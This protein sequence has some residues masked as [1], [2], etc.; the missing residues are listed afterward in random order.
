MCLLGRGVQGSWSAPVWTLMP[1]CGRRRCSKMQ[2]AVVSLSLSSV[3]Y[4][5]L[6]PCTYV[7][8]LSFLPLIDSWRSCRCYSLGGRSRAARRGE[9][10]LPGR[11][12]CCRGTGTGSAGSTGSGRSSMVVPPL[13][14]AVIM[15]PPGSGKGTVSARII[16]HFG[17]KH[18]SSGDLL[19]DNMQKRTGGIGRG[20]GGVRGGGGAS[21]FVRPTGAVPTQPWELP[22]DTAPLRER[23]TLTAHIPAPAPGKGHAHSSH[24]CPRPAPSVPRCAAPQSQLCVPPP[25]QRLADFTQLFWRP[26]AAEVASHPQPGVLLTLSLTSLFINYQVHLL[27]LSGVI[28]FSL[29]CYTSLFSHLRCFLWAHSGFCTSL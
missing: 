17:V 4:P 7:K 21:S 8:D 14:R 24:S 20:V 1:K 9:A 15:G 11:R 29:F 26:A 28:M 18:L 27:G 6:P 19:R 3:I 25:R 5:S 12:R 13:L 10:A 23:G 2:F 22:R 16:K